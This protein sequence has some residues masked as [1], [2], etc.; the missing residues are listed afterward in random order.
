MSTTEDKKLME[1]LWQDGTQ[2]GHILALVLKGLR[3]VVSQLVNGRLEY[4]GSPKTAPQ[5]ILTHEPRP[6]E[7]TPS[8]HP[9][10]SQ[11]LLLSLLAYPPV[12]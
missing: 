8:P 7:T 1:D 2:A 11:Y 9:T 6:Q 5:R 4:H 12:L 3:K 10:K